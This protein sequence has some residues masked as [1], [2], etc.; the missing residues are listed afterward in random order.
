MN[1]SDPLGAATQARPHLYPGEPLL[2]AAYGRVINFDVRGLTPDGRPA[3]GLLR[4]LGS[5]AAGFA[6]DFVSEALGG[7]DDSGSDRPPAPQVVAFGDRAGVLAHEFLRG[8]PV[9]AAIRRLWVLT[10]RRLLVLDEPVPEAEPE[11]EKSLL[12]KAIGF[13]REV[14]QFG[15][16]VAE[17]LTD[18]TK[19]YGDNREGEP[20]ALREFR[21][22]AELARDRIARAEIAERD[23]KPVLRMSLVDGSGLDFRFDA[24]EHFDWLLARTNGAR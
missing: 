18:R 19:T 13:G 2:W 1:F 9:Q 23:R 20:I 3:K 7:G 8:I 24:D 11:A 12:G 5:G 4:K 6:G 16:D 15:R 22:A 17:I 10:P 14:A 21:P